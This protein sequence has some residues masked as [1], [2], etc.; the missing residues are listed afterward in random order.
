[1]GKCVDA[2]PVVQDGRIYVG[3]HAGLFA[4]ISLENGI[5]EWVQ[6]KAF[7][8]DRIEAA[9]T[10]IPGA[11]LIG[12]LRG[13]LYCLDRE[14]GDVI[15]RFDTGGAIKSSPT[16]VACQ[17]S[18]ILASHGRRLYLIAIPEPGCQPSVRWNASLDSSGIVA[19][20]VCSSIAK[21]AF[22]CTLKGS[23]FA[24]HLSSGQFSKVEK[25]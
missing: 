11:I 14:N 21:L 6:S 18:I 22:T 16:F 5:F 1:M 25:E 2:A 19:K 10:V 15:W 3:S 24:S 12:T 17:N 13:I 9:A 23:I 4:C 7:E 20:V 8:G